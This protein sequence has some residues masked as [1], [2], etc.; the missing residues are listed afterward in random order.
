MLLMGDSAH[1]I[2]FEPVS[3]FHNAFITEKC[4]LLSVKGRFVFFPY[5]LTVQFNHSY[6][7]HFNAAIIQDLN[8]PFTAPHFK[9]LRLKHTLRSLCGVCAVGL[10]LHAQA[11][12][13]D[14]LIQPEAITDSQTSP[15]KKVE[16]DL[17][18]LLLTREIVLG[19]I[20]GDM[21]LQRGK[22]VDAYNMYLTMAMKTRDPRYAELAYKVAAMLGAKEPALEAA[23]LLKLLAPN[24]V[25]GQDLQ[26][27]SDIEKAYGLIDAQRYRPAYDAAKAILANAPD[28]VAALSLLA[29][30][31]DRLGRNSE[32]QATLEKLI[33]L[34][35]NNPENKNALGYFLADKNMRLGEA[36]Q[37]IQQ[38]HTARPDAGH[39]T[40]SMAWVAYRQGQLSDA[41]K[42]AEQAVAQDPHEE[43]QVHYAEILWA[44]DK[45]DQALEVFR[46][47][48]AGTPFLPSLR[49]TLERLNIPLTSVK[50]QPKKK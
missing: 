10:S 29:D 36:A 46:D 25:V 28:N 11:Q 44:N 4:V 9:S 34:D 30:V 19:T 13:P 47:V 16:Y 24:A 35:P 50:P 33:A 5:F 31:A 22:P 1:A 8:M 2:K 20:A 21:L 7:Y 27:H 26:V 49:D 32:A 3:L 39:I 38:A 15:V 17:P 14:E 6:A 12:T 40:D 42:Y 41:L 48:Y 43:S 18:K 45:H 23:K 37:L